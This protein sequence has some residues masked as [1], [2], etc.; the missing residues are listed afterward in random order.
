MGPR[1]GSDRTAPGPPLPGLCRAVR[2]LLLGS[3]KFHTFQL[4]LLALPREAGPSLPPSPKPACQLVETEPQVDSGPL[5]SLR[6][7]FALPRS[8]GP[9]SPMKEVAAAA[10]VFPSPLSLPRPTLWISL[11][12]NQPSS[13]GVPSLEG[14]GLGPVREQKV[15]LLMAPGAQ[16]QRDWK[17]TLHPPQEK[18][19][20]DPGLRGCPCKPQRTSERGWAPEGPS[21]HAAPS[22]CPEQ[23][24]DAASSFCLSSG[25]TG[26]RVMK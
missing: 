8:P 18:L 13:L 26:K 14:T 3:A 19:R 15:V 5:G 25:K 6:S 24:E 1:G 11:Q 12:A 7:C 17:A 22:T 23:T 21:S 10:L 9:G 20:P 2:P 16:R 4:V